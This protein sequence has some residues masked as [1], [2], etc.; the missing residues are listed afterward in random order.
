MRLGWKSYSDAARLAGWGLE[1]TEYEAKA[2]T[3]R[4]AAIGMPPP[5]RF[6]REA[7]ELQLDLRGS[8]GVFG[9][10]PGEPPKHVKLRLSKHTP[11]T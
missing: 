5:V 3:V 11:A 10:P 9:P 1:G 2:A 4:K 7:V 8:E 6:G